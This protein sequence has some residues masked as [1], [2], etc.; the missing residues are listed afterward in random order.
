MP[1]LAPEFPGSPCPLYYALAV[2]RAHGNDNEASFSSETSIP[3][4]ASCWD[5]RL[6][7]AGVEVLKCRRHTQ[8]WLSQCEAI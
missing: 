8:S 2:R 4:G 5:Q 3:N 1:R 7:V 6:D